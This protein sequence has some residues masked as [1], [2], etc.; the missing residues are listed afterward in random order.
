MQ[1]IQ[2]KWQR[3]LMLTLILS[4]PSAEVRAKDVAL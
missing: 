4:L 3:I 1:Q 2:V